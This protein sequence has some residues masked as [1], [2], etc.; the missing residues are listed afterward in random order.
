[1]SMLYDVDNKFQT[2]TVRDGL[3]PKAK[4]YDYKGNNSIF[5]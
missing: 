3:I 2:R 4:N 1:M 5:I